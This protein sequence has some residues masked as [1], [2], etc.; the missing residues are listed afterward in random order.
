MTQVLPYE[1]TITETQNVDV[2]QDNG[3]QKEME[4][5][6]PTSPK[7]P[8]PP[9]EKETVAAAEKRKPSKPKKKSMNKN[10]LEAKPPK[11][12]VVKEKPAELVPAAAP[13]KAS[14]KPSPFKVSAERTTVTGDVTSE[15]RT[16]QAP[17]VAV[18]KKVIEP[19]PKNFGRPAKSKSGSY[20]GKKDSLSGHHDPTQKLLVENPGQA[21]KR[22]C[23]LYFEKSKDKTTEV[24]FERFVCCLYN[25]YFFKLI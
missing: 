7:Q 11:V 20:S 18:P 15:T 25:I 17:F 14:E 9:N 6:K 19:V 13:K 3:D 8:Q 10:V 5:K 24:A 23:A 22:K 4:K 21:L 1:K 2:S 16:V 12:E